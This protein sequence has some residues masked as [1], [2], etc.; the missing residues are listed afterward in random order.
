ML[1]SL[2]FIGLIAIEFA[3]IADCNLVRFALLCT[4]GVII[5][6]AVSDWLGGLMAVIQ[7]VMI[8]CGAK[9]IAANEQY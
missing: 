5:A 1:M 4:L 9:H 7:C 6:I 2:I 8:V 3:E